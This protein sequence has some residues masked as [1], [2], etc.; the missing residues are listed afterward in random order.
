MTVDHNNHST[1]S[2]H[3]N[4]LRTQAKSKTLMML[5]MARLLLFESRWIPLPN[6]RPFGS[7]VLRFMQP[8]T[9]QYEELLTRLQHQCSSINQAL[10]DRNL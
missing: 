9:F 4:S 7:P 1:I 3:W 6:L 8:R 10:D 2:N 5:M